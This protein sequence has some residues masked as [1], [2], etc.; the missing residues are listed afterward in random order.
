MLLLWI[1]TRL[2][3]FLLVTSD[4]GTLANRVSNHLMTYRMVHY[5]YMLTK[6]CVATILPSVCV[7]IT[8]NMMPLTGMLAIGR[9]HPGLIT[10]CMFQVI[11]RRHRAH[12]QCGCSESWVLIGNQHCD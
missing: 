10:P 3:S 7:P 9:A 12:L 6:W 1:A 4:N 5:N 2:G 11:V 8:L